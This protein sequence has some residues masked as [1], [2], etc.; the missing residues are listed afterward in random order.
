M[1]WLVYK[2]NLNLQDPCLTVYPYHPL[3]QVLKA[4]SW[5]PEE[6]KNDTEHI[7]LSFQVPGQEYNL[8]DSFSCS[9]K[10]QWVNSIC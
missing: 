7:F 6:D 9:R 10:Y 3:P 4:T 8:I 1:H 2:N 5:Q